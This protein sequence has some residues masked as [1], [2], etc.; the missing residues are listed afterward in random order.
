MAATA[1]APATSPT[2]SEA[3]TPSDAIARTHH[4]IYDTEAATVTQ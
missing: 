2:R 3:A 1:P 4:Q